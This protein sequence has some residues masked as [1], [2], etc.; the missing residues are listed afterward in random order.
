VT[1]TADPILEV[2][3]LVQQFNVNG[4]TVHAV[5]DISFD[6]RSHE[7][8]GLVGESGSGKSTLARAILQAPSP[9]SGEVW[10][11]GH[12]MTKQSKKQLFETRR[13]IQT[14]F[15][16]P[17]SSLDPKWTVRAIVREPLDAYGV[18]TRSQR[19]EKVDAIL[20]MVGLDPTSFGNRKPPQLS[21]GQ[22]QRVAIAR[23]LALEPSLLIFDEVVSALDVLTQAHILN[24]LE[25]LREE[26]QISS[27]FVAHDLALVKQVS[28]RVAVMY[29]GRLCEI[30]PAQSVLA[31]PRHH[32]TAALVEA[33]PLPDPKNREERRGNVVAGEVPSPLAPPSGCPFRTRCPAAQALCAA[34]MP[35]LTS[36]GPDHFVACHFPVAEGALP[37]SVV[38]AAAA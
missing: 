21:G 26:L 19:A 37:A 33:I 16:D 27:L 1:D 35:P 9:K 3:N 32:Y 5:S 12:D 7:T 11:R 38:T 2:K 8:L 29:L 30:G 10:F 28:D 20:D 4:G 13:H 31:K 18:G 17:F 24:L 22:C 25:K 6:I 36:M 23:A 14:V 15:Q 34:E